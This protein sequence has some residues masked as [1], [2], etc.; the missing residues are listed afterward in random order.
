VDREEL[1]IKRV[2]GALRSTLR[3]YDVVARISDWKFGMLLPEAEDGRMSAMPRIKKAIQT[4]VEEIRKRIKEVRVDLRFGHA[5]YPEDGDD[6]EKLIFKS[7]ILK[8]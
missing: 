2:A 5:S 6:Y 3:E 8:L 1:V 4:E 7:N